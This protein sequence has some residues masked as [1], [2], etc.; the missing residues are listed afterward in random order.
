MTMCS[1]RKWTTTIGR[2][3]KIHCTWKSMWLVDV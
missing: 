1:V 3:Q 2:P